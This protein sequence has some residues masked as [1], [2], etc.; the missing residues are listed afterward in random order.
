MDHDEIFKKEL[1]PRIEWL[2]K[3]KKYI[4]AFFFLCVALEQELIKLIELYEE[5]NS[6]LVG[7]SGYRLNLKK[8]RMARFKQMMLGQLKDYLAIFVGQGNLIKELDYFIKLRNDCVHH[9]LDKNTLT[10][11]GEVSKNLNRYYRLLYW[12]LRRQNKLLK[13][14]IRSQNRKAKKVKTN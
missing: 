8:Y 3:E 13:S 6:R 1:E 5:H 4:E 7:N 14:A 9:I 10:L 12:L 11:D 2:R